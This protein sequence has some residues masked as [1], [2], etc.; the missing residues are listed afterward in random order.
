MFTCRGICWILY[1]H[2]VRIP[3]LC[4]R[5]RVAMAQEM[6][7]EEHCSYSFI[8][9]FSCTKITQKEAANSSKWKETLFLKTDFKPWVHCLWRQGDAA[10]RLWLETPGGFHKLLTGGRKTESSVRLRNAQTAP[11]ICLAKNKTK[12]SKT[13]HKNNQEGNSPLQQSVSVL[14]PQ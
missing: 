9:S 8:M 1:G 6:Y 7:P 5:R 12:W 11:G 4:L 10:F 14:P 3:Q 13:K 2:K